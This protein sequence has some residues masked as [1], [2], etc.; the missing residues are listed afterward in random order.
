MFN[1]FLSHCLLFLCVQVFCSLGSDLSVTSTPACGA[2][3][4]DSASCARV[5]F[6]AVLPVHIT[7]L[8]PKPQEK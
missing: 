7:S 4:D 5:A 8:A 1:H 3:E 2:L 6:P